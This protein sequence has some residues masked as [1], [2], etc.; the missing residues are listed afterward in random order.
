MEERNNGGNI[1]VNLLVKKRRCGNDIV[2][3]FQFS[4]EPDDILQQ[5]RN[6]NRR[7]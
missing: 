2:S 3:R 1:Q 4:N 7:D 5:K 6:T